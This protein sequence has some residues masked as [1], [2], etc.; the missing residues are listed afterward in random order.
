M[1]ILLVEPD[2]LLAATYQQALLGAGHSVITCASAQ[3]AIMAADQSQ[4][5][6]IILELQLVEHSGIEFLYEFRSYVDW[7][8]IPVILQT[9]VPPAEFNGNHWLLTSELGVV[10]YLYKPQTSLHQLLRAVNEQTVDAIVDE[11]D[12]SEPAVDAQLPVPA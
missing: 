5:D 1:Q 12:A 6:L 8:S 3:A 4:P 11:P 2:R 7:Q 10:S 9:Q